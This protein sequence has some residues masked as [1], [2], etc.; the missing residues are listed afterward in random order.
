MVVLS[1]HIFSN[2]P[3]AQTPD[4]IM[5]SADPLPFTNLSTIPKIEHMVCLFELGFM[6]LP[7]FS[8]ISQL[9]RKEIQVSI[10]HSKMSNWI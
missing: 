1:R 2:D 3:F 8:A 9:T 4:S 5:I 10:L 6:S 7:Q